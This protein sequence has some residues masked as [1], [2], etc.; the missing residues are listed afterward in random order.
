MSEELNRFFKSISFND[1]AFNEA[2][3]DR[4][5]FKKGENKFLV[6]IKNKN[7][8]PVGSVNRLFLCAMN[9]INGEKNCDINI[10]YDEV[11]DEDITSYL[12]YLINDIILKRP[13]LISVKK[14]SIE[15]IDNTIYFHVLNDFERSDLLHESKGILNNLNRYGLGNFNIEV[16]ISEDERKNIQEEIE[17]EKQSVS[18]KKEEESPIILGVHKDGDV[19]KLNNILGEMKNIIVEVYIFQKEVTERQGKKGP[20]F[21][22]NMKVSDKTDSYLMKLVRFNEEEFAHLNKKLN[23][24][25]WYR[26]HGHMEMDE[27][28]HQMV[29]NARNIE[30]IPSKDVSVKDD[31]KE[32]RVELHAHTMMSMMDGVV[33]TA[34]LAKFAMKLGHKAVAVTDHN[35]LQAYPDIYNALQ[36]A[37]R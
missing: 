32:K 7:V 26:V 13:S 30:I 37:I 17:L 24:G 31:C 5:V 3:L 28:L 12:D 15:V 19:I 29:I 25:S 36:K 16:N 2:L 9:G 22:M 21:I 18:S 34:G 33:P 8:L 10:S 23:V 35:S 14:S 4:V 6:Y 1:D 20:V 11:T 27:Y